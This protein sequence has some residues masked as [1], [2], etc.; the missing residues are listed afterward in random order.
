MTFVDLPQ[1]VS[2]FLDANIFVYSYTDDVSFG[3]ACTALLE[4][5]ELQELKGFLSTHVMSEVAH[6]LMT[7][8]AC[9]IFGWSCTGVARQLRRHPGH[10]QKLHKFRA[11]LDGIVG[12]GIQILSVHAAD[13]LSA[14][15]L[16]Q[17]HGL[18]SGDAL[19]L[20]V[21]QK[22]GLSH[23]ASNDADFDRVPGIMRYSP[24]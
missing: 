16:S 11:C 5:V 12:I 9:Q 8:E 18:L 17:R 6:R 20:A 7:L 23:L 22:H 21:M 3:A 19:L 13:V 4:R 1:H 2:V 14:G 24:V 15:D 10:F